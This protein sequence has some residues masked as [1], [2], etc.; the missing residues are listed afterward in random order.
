MA[1]L[2]DD[3]RRAIL[4]AATLLTGHKRRQIQ[5]D[6]AHAYCRSSARLAETTFG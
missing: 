4:L 2:T 3:A 5:A 6:T 1:D